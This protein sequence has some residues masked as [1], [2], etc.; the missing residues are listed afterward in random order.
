[1]KTRFLLI[2][3]NIFSV[4]G[5]S[6]NDSRLAQGLSSIATIEKITM[7]SL[8][9]EKLLQMEMERRK[10]G[11][12]PR[13]AESMEVNISPAT[14]GNWE[15]SINGNLVWRIIIQSAKAKSINLGFTKYKMPIGGSLILYSPDYQ[16]ILG[17]FTPADNEDHEQLWTPVLPGDEI[18]IEVQILEKSKSE[19][20]LELKYVNHD[21]L[22]FGGLAS[23]SCNID[24]ICGAMDGWDQVDEYRDIIRSVAVIGTGGNTYCSGFLVN[25]ARND[26]TPYFI[27]AKHCGIA[28]GSAPSLVAYWNYENSYCREL[29]SPDNSNNGDGTLNDFNTGAIYRASN[30]ESDFALLELDDPVSETANAF[31]AGWSNLAVAPTKAI[32]IHHPGAEEKRISFDNDALMLTNG[33]ESDPNDNFNHVRVID[34]DNGTTE[35]GSSGSPLFNQDKQ[36]VGQLHGGAAACGN[37]KSDWYGSFATSWL[38]GGTTSTRLKDWLDPDNTGITTLDGREIGACGIMVK[39]NPSA[40]SLCSPSDTVFQIIASETF[41]AAVTISVSTDIPGVVNLILDNNPINPGDSTQLHLTVNPFVPTGNYS[42]F[43]IGTDGVETVSGQID[44]IIFETA[45]SELGLITPT[46]EEITTSIIPRFRWQAGQMETSYELQIATDSNFTNIIETITE[47]DTNFYDNT[48]LD[49]LTNYFWRI[50]GL[51]LCGVGAWSENYSF[52]TADVHCLFNS[53]ID[54][55]IVLPEENTPTSFSTIEILENGLVTD[56]NITSLDIYHSWVGDLIVTIESPSGITVTLF[57]QPGVPTSNFGCPEDNLLLT[58]DDE[59]EEVYETFDATCNQGNMA[60][61]GTFQ[62]FESLKAFNGEIAAGT[63]KLAIIDNADGDGGILNGWNLDICSTIIPD[64][65]ITSSMETPTFCLGESVVFQ[66]TL[67]SDFDSTGINLSA[68]GNPIGS[69][70]TFS[71]NNV[72]PGATVE[73]TIQGLNSIGN[74]PILFFANDGMLSFNTEITIKIT[75]TPDEP[76]LMSPLD[77]QTGIPV[78]PTL[79]WNESN[80][81]SEYLVEIAEDGL[82]NNIISSNSQ[83]ALEYT[84]P[85]LIENQQYFWRVLAQNDC[86]ETSSPVFN[87]TTDLI[88][89]IK[90]IDDDEIIIYPN[91]TNGKLHIG[92]AQPLQDKLTIEIISPN[93]QL[94]Q[95]I[96]TDNFTSETELD[97]KGFSNG[98]YLIRIVSKD[99]VLRKKIVLQK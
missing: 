8:E 5:F 81:A 61:E 94:V 88:D 27:T 24:V 23:G 82:F 20:E 73:V 14:H 87:F 33:L 51:N 75:N 3:F 48:T 67:G 56:V 99:V 26:C 98:V 49:V 34:W 47:L 50:R 93:G 69:T 42:I 1:M 53:S 64:L 84:T 25:N 91:P 54:V 74:Y 46:D 97:L 83:V 22:G 39:A 11:L 10:P 30:D 90:I 60:I 37:N 38:G 32:G 4:F 62:P 29:D 16:H 28:A 17:P 52:T 43:I 79:F 12:A 78:V 72:L 59:S 80:Y 63:W 41:G 13:F 95:Q 66:I 21:F 70:I 89:D 15:S 92:F 9:N 77:G 71:E 68:S 65:S 55:P 7:P 31:F 44:V 57:D 36:V 19:L 40:V 85:P 6:Q 96:V 45:P 58:F 18:V 86:G 35:Q 2:A 76:H